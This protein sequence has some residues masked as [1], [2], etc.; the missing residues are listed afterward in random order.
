[1]TDSHVPGTRSVDFDVYGLV[2]V[3]LQDA[4]DAVVANAR[5]VLGVPATDCEGRADLLVDFTDRISP[6]GPLR[7]LGLRQA[8]FDDTHF[9]LV[10][11]EALVRFD[12]SALGGPITMLAER[13]ASR[14]PLLIPILSVLL[15][16]AGHVLLHAAAFE[17]EGRGVLVTGWQKGGKTETLLPFMAAGARFIADEWTIVGGSPARI[18][19]ASN[20]ARLWDWHLRQLPDY[21]NRIEARQRVRI[22]SWRAFDRGYA[23][24]APLVRRTAPRVA[25][26]ADGL[27]IPGGS[28]WQAADQIA[29]PSLFG[30]RILREPIRADRILMP[31]VGRGQ[32]VRLVPQDSDLVAR[33]MVHSLT[34]ERE[35]LADAVEQFHFAFPDRSTTGWEA[36]PAA[37]ER[38]LRE[39]FAGVPAFELRHPYPVPLRQLYEAASSIF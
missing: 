26:R 8:A 23:V 32:D 22:R 35:A 24:I 11:G 1:M 7:F 18:R 10:D 28:A 19:G 16:S 27:R 37:E 6:D 30:E 20:V 36:V 13:A 15:A 5:S 3:R 31:I 25:R 29:P 12:P 2:R 33:R 34:F 39:S 14:V 9:Y 17:Y 38:I 4:P 21:W